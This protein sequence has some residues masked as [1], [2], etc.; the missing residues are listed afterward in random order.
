MHFYG[1]VHRQRV[2]RRRPDQ[3]QEVVEEREYHR[4]NRRHDYVGRP[5]HQSEEV[6]VV[7]SAER[8]VY[9][10]LACYEFAFGPVG[11]ATGLNEPE[12]GLTENLHG[13]NFEG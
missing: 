3:P 1:E 11:L 7:G 4:E 10:M 6:E 12:Y 2:K 8:E 9:G 5:P 13:N